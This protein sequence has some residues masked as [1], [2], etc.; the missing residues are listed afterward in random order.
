MSVPCARFLSSAR[1][2]LEVTCAYVSIVST[3]FLFGIYVHLNRVLLGIYMHLNIV[4]LALLYDKYT[5]LYVH[6][7]VDVCD[8]EMCGFMV[9]FATNHI[10][11]MGTGI[12]QP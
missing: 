8:D 3:W 10:S 1:L 7:Q 4:C 9:V 6:V 5:L 11:L 2:N 12:I